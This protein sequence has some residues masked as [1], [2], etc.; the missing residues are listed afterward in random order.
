VGSERLIETHNPQ[1]EVRKNAET[2]IDWEYTEEAKFLYRMAGIIRNR[3]VDPIHRVNREQAPDP[4]ISFGNL[5][6]K[7][8]LAA[9][10]LVR[11]PQG[12]NYEITL[13]T[14]HYI[15]DKSDS[16]ADKKQWRFGRWAQLETLTHEQI[17]L[18]QQTVGEDPVIIGKKNTYHNKEFVDKCETVGLHPEL[19]TGIHLRLAD[20]PFE[21]LMDEL[22]I[23]KPSNLPGLPPDLSIDWFRWLLK[24][25]GKERKGRSTLKKWSCP[26]C[27]LNVRIGIKADPML[28]HHTCSEE[29]GEPVFLLRGDVYNG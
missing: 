20:G 29:K 1:P 8:T 13:N 3:L 21:L 24:F 27:G 5:R 19:G 15:E 11:N 10:T 28:I 23:E 14:Q 12:L 25:Q 9:Y 2:A 16:G 4:V 26:E 6:N 18:W 17:H 7:N 22:G